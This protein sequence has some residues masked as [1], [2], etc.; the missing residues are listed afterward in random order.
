M[1]PF[2]RPDYG[3]PWA[4]T[5]RRTT[6][7]LTV[8]ILGSCFY[9]WLRLTPWWRERGFGTEQLASLK[10]QSLLNEMR[11]RGG[12]N[13]A[14]QEAQSYVL[15]FDA[16]YA[17][18]REYHPEV[19]ADRN[20]PNPFPRLLPGKSYGRLSAPA[21]QVSDPLIWSDTVYYLGQNKRQWVLDCGG[22]LHA[23]PGS[24][25]SRPD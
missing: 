8:V 11:D 7:F 20:A 15:S 16:F 19:V 25:G 22:F 6:L 1:S 12:P 18:V 3:S 14:G 23:A 9:H 10:L 4:D 21:T 17:Y 2:L 5:M 13:I 24:V